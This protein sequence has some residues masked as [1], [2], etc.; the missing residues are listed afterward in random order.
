MPGSIL[1]VSLNT[2]ATSNAVNTG[3][4]AKDSMFTMIGD[5]DSTL[6]QQSSDL[7]TT[8]SSCGSRL[9]REWKAQVT[10][11][12]VEAEYRFDVSFGDGHRYHT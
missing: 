2:M 4:L 3:A 6:T 8:I 9:K 5:N 12:A 7:P 10:G 11:D 1:T